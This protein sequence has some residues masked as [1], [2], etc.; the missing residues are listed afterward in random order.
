MSNAFENHSH[1]KEVKEVCARLRGAG[2]QAFLAGGCVRDLL[3]NR[4]PNDFDIATD[5]I[6]DQVEALFP[7][8]LGVGK[9]FGVMILPFD[10]F[11]LEVA[12]FRQDLEY[13]DGRR[14]EGVKFS[15]PEE[16]A[17]RRDFTVNALFYD[18]ESS[19]VI[20]YVGGQTDIQKRIIRTVGEPAKRFEE[21]KL[22]VLRGIRF[23]AQ[24][25]FTVEENTFVAIKTFARETSAVSRERVRDEMVKLLKTPLRRKGLDLLW[26]API[27]EGIFPMLATK[28]R[29]DAAAWRN[30][31]SVYSKWQSE[32]EADVAALLALF[33][34][35][36]RQEAGFRDTH[37][38]D[39]RL[40]NKTIEAVGFAL[41]HL[42]EFLEPSKVRVGEMLLLLA[43][44]HAK[45]AEL[46]S[47]VIERSQTNDSAMQTERE[48]YLE[49]LIGPHPERRLPAAFVTGDDMKA[50]GWT[51]GKEMGAAL[52]EAY[53]KQLEGSLSSR[54]EALAWIKA[55]SRSSS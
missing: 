10:G 29:A 7:K 51:P 27:F 12:T 19:K 24:L 55:A 36:V 31:F 20:D 8:A 16:D 46:V 4:E 47:G 22:R 23:A 34:F 2:F 42:P 49:K 54:A 50:A 43:S 45:P 41:K 6:P 18:I 33:F 30:R 9:A 37:L 48:A 39:L 13:R 3:M 32:A 28:A 15:S 11:Q 26:I 38:K 35:P 40:D 14:P 21:D 44:P 53:L 52:H 5:S 25:D 1:W 17:K